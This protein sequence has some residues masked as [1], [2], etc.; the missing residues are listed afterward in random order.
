MLRRGLAKVENIAS[1]L[2][3]P[4]KAYQNACELYKS[5]RDAGLCRGR[6]I[7]WVAG[8]SVYIACQQMGRPISLTKL[9]KQAQVEGKKVGKV[10]RLMKGELGLEMYPAGSHQL[11]HGIISGLDTHPDAVALSQELLSTPQFSRYFDR[12]HSGY[13]GG[14]AAA[15]VYLVLRQVF[16]DPVLK[17]DVAAQAGISSATL[18]NALRYAWDGI[19]NQ[20]VK[21]SD[22]TKVTIIG[23][24]KQSNIVWRVFI[25]ELNHIDPHDLPDCDRDLC[26]DHTYCQV[27][28]YL[29]EEQSFTYR[30][31]P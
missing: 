22:L 7:R 28:R 3:L 31:Y 18:C 23:M 15:A 16:N 11:V 30:N 10:I 5:A 9:A 2:R 17:K 19:W 24:G 14:I 21:S 1:D 29:S 27:K 26:F 12:Y 8:A 13:K 25:P 20:W 6:N 4:L